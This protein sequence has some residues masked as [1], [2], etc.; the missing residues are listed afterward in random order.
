MEGVYQHASMPASSIY[1]G[2]SKNALGFPSLVDRFSGYLR[3]IGTYLQPPCQMGHRSPKNNSN[4]QASCSRP[5]AASRDVP[6]LPVY[7]VCHTHTVPPRG[8]CAPPPCHHGPTK[9][10]IPPSP[11]YAI[12]KWNFKFY[13][14]IYRGEFRGPY[15]KW[16]AP[17]V[18]HTNFEPGSPYRKVKTGPL[19]P[20]PLGITTA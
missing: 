16:Q 10:K 1:S 3:P 4:P 18:C 7:K 11:S 19:N 5:Y 15:N 12:D 14:P 9:R 13:G 6:G 8:P 20:R 17:R 2:A